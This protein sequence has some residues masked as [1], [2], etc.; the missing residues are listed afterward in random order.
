MAMGDAMK[1]ELEAR[2]DK[3]ATPSGVAT[4]SADIDWST[5]SKT[6]A[7]ENAKPGP[8]VWFERCVR[9]PRDV[10]SKYEALPFTE[11]AAAGFRGD[12]GLEPWVCVWGKDRAPKDT[13][14]LHE[15][16]GRPNISCLYSQG[17]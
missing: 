3:Q 1:K 14:Y 5:A 6:S 2:M 10:F 17:W 11:L 13:A 8:H 9:V 12:D 15:H 7:A 16:E 4:A